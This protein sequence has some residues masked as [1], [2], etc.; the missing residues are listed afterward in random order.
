LRHRGIQ[1][2]TNAA[3]ADVANLGDFALRAPARGSILF[4]IDGYR[5]VEREAS[6]SPF[7]LLGLNHAFPP[8]GVK[9]R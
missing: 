9:W 5:N 4:V 2:E 8:S 6:R 3:C 1:I 7:L